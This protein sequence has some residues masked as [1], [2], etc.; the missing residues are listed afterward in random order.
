MS[1]LG[2]Q[3]LETHR[4]HVP[5]LDVMLPPG[6]PS[7]GIVLGVG[8]GDVANLEREAEAYQWDARSQELIQTPRASLFNIEAIPV[9]PKKFLTLPTD[10]HAIADSQPEGRWK[11]N[12]TSS[13][14]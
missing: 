8:S 14:E 12:R 5:P 13:T 9:C 7:I 10:R 1:R 11:R 6:G 4:P 2:E 3:G